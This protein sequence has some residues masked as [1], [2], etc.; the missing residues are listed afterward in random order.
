[1]VTP[2]LQAVLKPLSLIVPFSVPDLPM[3]TVELEIALMFMYSTEPFLPQPPLNPLPHPPRP[4]LLRPQVKRPPPLAYLAGGNMMAATPR[5]RMDVLS[6]TNKPVETPTL[7]NLAL[8][9]VSVQGTPLPDWNT[10]LNASATTTFTTELP[11]PIHPNATWLALEMRKRCAVRVTSCP[12][13][14]QEI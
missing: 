10:A 7:S 4:V 13:T 3:N 1:M 8:I 2:L 5:V 9:P 14:T 6:P 11:S 12:F